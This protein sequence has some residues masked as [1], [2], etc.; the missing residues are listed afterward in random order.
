MLFEVMTAPALPII[1][2]ILPQTLFGVAPVS[3]HYLTLDLTLV[4]QRS[5]TAMEPENERCFT[6][7]PS[8]IPESQQSI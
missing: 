8:D 6:K 1:P 4:T 2:S 5:H 3:L 7:R